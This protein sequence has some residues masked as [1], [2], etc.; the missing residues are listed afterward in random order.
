MTK[1]EAE[2]IAKL[3]EVTLNRGISEAYK[4]LRAALAEQL[5][6]DVL[7]GEASQISIEIELHGGYTKEEEE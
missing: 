4:V 6:K 5:E 3:Y 7:T 1:K 2:E